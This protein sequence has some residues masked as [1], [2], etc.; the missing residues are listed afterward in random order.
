MGN[1]VLLSGIVCA[2]A[3]GCLPDLPAEPPPPP[4]QPPTQPTG[5]MAFQNSFYGVAVSMCG[6]CHSEKPNEGVLVPQNPLFACSNVL[7][8]YT[9]AKPF[10]DFANPSGSLLVEYAGNNHCGLPARCGNSAQ[11]VLAQVQTWVAG[12]TPLPTTPPRVP[13]AD[14]QALQLIQTD[15]YNRPASVQQYVR[16]FTLEYWGNT[17]GQP[18]L[19][20]AD[21]ARSALIKMLNVTSTGRQIVQPVAIDSDQLIYAVD[22]RDLG[23]TLGAW[24]N[25][26]ATDPYFQPSTFAPA[27]QVAAYQTMRADWFVYSIPN[28]AVDAYFVFLGID[29]DDPTIDAH[30]HVDRFGDMTIGAPATVRAGFAVSRTEGSNRIISWHQTNMFGTG[31][32]GSGHLFK[33]YNMDTDTGNGNIFS[34]PYRPTT[35][36]PTTLTPSVYDFTFGDSDNLFTLP[37]GLFG[38]YTTLPDAGKIANAA[39]AGNAFP[40]PT[41]CFQCHDNQTNTIPFVDQVHDAITAANSD[42][43]PAALR[44]ELLGMYDQQA[45][46]SKL[47]TAGTQFGTA[48]GELHLPAIDIAGTPTGR[49]TE[50]MNVVT[51]N[52]SIVLGVDTAAAELGTTTSELV[53]AIKSSP[54]LSLQLASLIAPS[55]VIR[56]DQWEATYTQVRRLLLP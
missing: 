55:G 10:V 12:D 53:S 17:N 33:S 32:V 45:I 4:K 52:Y 44:T 23:W 29:T 39:N 20:S 36:F 3:A 22:M 26:K 31:A 37:N 27:V 38:Y 18:P 25:L 11:A 15:L 47:A 46:D 6:G 48:Y 5:L 14:R 43:F 35:N 40:G 54:V 28:S 16:Y 51:N 56:R 49:G 34:H 1:V 19:V 13:V 8:A 7:Y 24:N 21:V 50:V 2:L 30:N 42:A 41:G 9:A